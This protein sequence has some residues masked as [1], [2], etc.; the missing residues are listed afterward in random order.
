MTPSEMPPNAE[1]RPGAAPRLPRRSWHWREPR[2]LAQAV[3]FFVIGY[4]IW[5]PVAVGV[6]LPLVGERSLASWAQWRVFLGLLALLGALGGALWWWG[7]Q[8][9]VGWLGYSLRSTGRMLALVTTLEG[10]RLATMSAV[11]WVG[12]TLLTATVMGVVFSPLE[13][14]SLARRVRPPAA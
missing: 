2:S 9:P 12:L 11:G 10:P 14:W 7:G 4:L 3:V 8:R 6:L 5:Q 1:R 13:H